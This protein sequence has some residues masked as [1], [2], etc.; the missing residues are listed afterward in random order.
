MSILQSIC[1]VFETVSMSLLFSYILYVGGLMEHSQ[2]DTI[3][4]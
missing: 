3:I 2:V 1:L 4:K